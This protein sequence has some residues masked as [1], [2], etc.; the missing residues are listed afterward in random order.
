MDKHIEAGKGSI[1]GKSEQLSLTRQAS[2][3]IGER[4]KGQ[5]RELWVIIMNKLHDGGQLNKIQ[6]FSI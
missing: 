2:R 5:R 3:L 6:L 1:M 4:I